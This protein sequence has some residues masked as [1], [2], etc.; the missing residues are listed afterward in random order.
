LDKHASYYISHALLFFTAA[1][2]FTQLLTM[3]SGQKTAAGGS[4]KSAAFAGDGVQVAS[5]G[6]KKKA[7]QNFL[8]VCGP[9]NSGKTSIFYHL[10]TKEI[11]TTVTSIEINETPALME[12]KIP[13]QDATKKLNIMDIP[14]HYHFRE[15]LNEVLDEQP[16]A[17]LVVVDSKEK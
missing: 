7:R 13:G 12:V 15:R 6:K 4:K 1:F 5:T 3:F 17:I 16:R 11:P 2:A 8:I 9:T 10:L 14:G